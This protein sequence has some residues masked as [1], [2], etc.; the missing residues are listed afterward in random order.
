MTRNDQR[1]IL[2]FYGENKNDAVR[3]FDALRRH[4][5]GNA[6]LA[7][8]TTRGDAPLPPGLA[9]YLKTLVP[10][11]YVVAGRVS[12]PRDTNMLAELRV[13]ESHSVFILN[14]APPEE[15]P[16]EARYQAG[17]TGTIQERFRRLAQ[18]HSELCD[19]P[20]RYLN[21]LLELADSQLNSAYEALKNATLLGHAVTTTG[22]WLLDNNYLFE[23]NT[24][25]V[26]SHLPKRYGP[27]L[28]GLRSEQG[29]PRIYSLAQALVAF[30]N[31]AVDADAVTASLQAYQE[32]HS[33]NL[34]ELWLFPLALRLAIVDGAS[35]VA[36]RAAYVQDTREHAYFWT[37]RILTAAR[38]GP[39]ALDE[40]F[41][42]LAQEPLARSETFLN[43]LAEQ[44]HEED[45]ALARFQSEVSRLLSVSLS[46]VVRHEHQSE[47]ADRILIAN[48][49]GSLRRMA[50]IDYAEI[51]EA[52]SRVERLLRKDPADSYRKADAETRNRCRS[53]VE[54]LARQSQE[55]EERVA[56]L[57][58][59]RAAAQTTELE[60][61]VEYHLLGPGLPGM[62]S[63][64]GARI[65]AGLRLTR[66]I[67]RH[68]LFT[69]LG[70][71]VALTGVLT[72][73]FLQAAHGPGDHVPEL[74]WL[75][76]VLAL[77]PLSEFAIQVVNALL[78]S[79][80]PPA[81]L[82]KLRFEDGIPDA[83]PAMVAVPMMFNN[84]E[85][86]DRELEKLETRYLG[87]RDPQL[88]FALLADF[89]DA[90]EQT[91][92]EDAALLERARKGIDALRLRY[93]GASFSLF[94]REREWSEGECAWIGR[95]RK[96]GKVED[97]NSVLCGEEAAIQSYPPFDRRVAFVIV[98]DADTQLPAGSARKLIETIAHPLNRVQLS[99]DGRERL[100]G[101]TIIQ[102][103]VSIGLPGASVTR[104]TKIFADARG[105]DPYCQAV[106]DLYQDLFRES[107]FHG[108]AIYDVR[109]MHTILAGRFPDN[110]ILSHDLIEG[111]HVGVAAASQVELFENLPTD[112]PSY[113][114]R[115]HRWT[116]GDWQI[117]P[118]IRSRVP[119]GHGR[120]ERNVLRL[121]NRWQILDNLR[122]SLVAPVSLA[123]LFVAWL[124]SPAGGISTA[125]IALTV[126]IPALA[127]V[128]DRLARN[129]S[130][131]THGTIGLAEEAQ[132][133][134]VYL[135]LLAHQ[136]WVSVDAI[137]RY[138]YRRFISKKQLLEWQTA[139][140]AETTSRLHLSTTM[141]QCVTIA[142]ASAALGV[143]LLAVGRLGPAL[144][145]LSLWGA[146]PLVIA[147]L[148]RPVPRA[149]PQPLGD[150]D[151][152]YLKVVA[153]RIWRT[154]DDL[155]TPETGWLPPDNTQLALR[156]EV[157]Q[158]TSPTNIGLWFTSALAAADMGFLTPGELARRC[159]LSVATMQRMERYEGHWLNWYSLTDHQPLE[160]K[161]VSTVDSGNLLVCLWVL[162]QGLRE[163]T[164]TPLAGQSC[165]SGLAA[166]LGTLEEVMGKDAAIALPR[167]NLRR[168]LESGVSGFAVIDRLR[169]ARHPLQNLRKSLG[170]F[171]S[172]ESEAAYWVEKMEEQCSA[173]L[174]HMERY[175]GWMDTLALAPDVLLYSI[176]PDLVAARSRAV[177]TVPS[178][179]TMANG[180]HK[181][182]NA[183]F[184][185]AGATAGT[186]QSAWLEQLTAEYQAAQERA[187]ETLA[188]LSSLAEEVDA[189]ANSIDMSFLYDKQRK[190]FG[191]GYELGHPV[192]FRSH[193]DLLASECRLAS[194]AAI[195]KGDVPVEHWH[196]LGRPYVS[197]GNG[198][199]LLSWS[200]TMFEYLMPVLFM[201]PFENSFLAEAAHL[202]ISTQREYGS[203]AKRP[204]GI[205]EAAYS[206]L[207]ANQIYQYRAFGVPELGLKPGLEKDWV[208]SPYSTLLALQMQT[209]A[210]LENLRTL[211]ALN[212]YGPMGFYESIDYTRPAGP[213]LQD[214]VIIHSYMAHHQGMGMGAIANTV[215]GGILQRR[216]HALLAVR[217]VEFLLFERVPAARSLLRRVRKDRVK[218]APVVAGETM[219][220][221]PREM[222][223]VPAVQLLGNGEYALAVTNGGSGFSR[224]RNFD[225]GRWQADTTLDGYGAYFYLRDIRSGNTW[226][227]APQPLGS[228]G[229]RYSVTFSASRVRFERDVFG[230]DQAYE[231]CVAPDDDVEIRRFTF[232]N[233]GGR[234]RVLDVTSFLELSMA[235]HAA[236]R[237]HPAFSKLFVQTEWLA[238]HQALLA[239]RRKRSPEDA[240]I[241][242]AHMVLV[243]A[244]LLRVEFE[245]SRETFLG[246]NRGV[247]DPEA[248]HRPLHGITG[249]VLDPAFSIRVRF[250][251]GARERTVVHYLTMAAATRE[252]LLALVTQYGK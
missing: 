181:E 96:R 177:Q 203:A 124:L 37:N 151:R 82:P 135:S 92:P 186:K 165:L 21:I 206:A 16:E 97:L 252:E 180:T 130:K 189:M 237:G 17:A 183:V 74:V 89:I 170:W 196:A 207:D 212:L 244:P 229:G 47:T 111:A 79:T 9:R 200:G 192:V 216:F 144:L 10:N 211:R 219:D 99:E 138:F 36:L 60:R 173:W 76:A 77:F 197:T 218:P 228:P 125:L 34:A 172:G 232:A 159:R 63:V 150:D 191:I 116:R 107:I 156:V 160:P 221:N 142:L 158:R 38:I 11:E 118:W 28:P 83:Y 24:A 234:A 174:A 248:L 56:E 163:W 134:V 152:D 188:E 129:M 147:W 51:F 249:T 42:G 20:K 143:V 239:Y 58:V 127:P 157:A 241:Y 49:V 233:R 59:A 115:Q 184:A 69:Y 226:S 57:T 106:S 64:A 201:N 235:P 139:E 85:T 114:R 93:P 208:V 179:E 131:Q 190:L 204:W 195:A 112:Y 141:R 209:A 178:L 48:A 7:N 110:T 26:K 46:D 5:R 225:I 81:P 91:M 169:Q 27:N 214:G 55:T 75:L 54:R 94:Y 224:W 198:Q 102:P 6:W 103:R 155:V 223:A 52:V 15:R 193:Y 80:M 243:D 61:H 230:I 222:G 67:Y 217:S 145:F 71:I 119:D 120:R 4:L 123:M 128:I 250:A 175:L 242:T 45:T 164:K 84:A 19:V 72:V 105:T 104:F 2:S 12:L 22:E 32:V 65:P 68:P 194:F 236:D 108:K 113:A 50:Q 148:G 122:R 247:D 78:V 33:L 185:L 227:P 88:C 8:G 166:T 41:A 132:R 133:A 146:S 187:R 53:A 153:R 251:I 100:S 140:A 62:E 35:Q 126:A 167:G 101:Y 23:V 168:M 29:K 176:H 39:A 86:V 25:E 18:G 199:V 220:R 40:M 240:G 231:I 171:A 73:L 14:E 210:S 43:V 137:A 213:D 3:T 30:T 70:A 44:L 246:R 154:F 1:L 202:A 161:Y 238:E 98:L 13:N 182:L 87:N 245:S 215:C 121:V 109:A 117:S 205:S 149:Y 66:W 95:E 31:Y 162:G 90:A 136:A